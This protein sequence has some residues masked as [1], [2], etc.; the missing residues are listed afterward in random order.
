MNQAN[1]GRVR[2]G[3][4][5][6]GRCR[7]VARLAVEALRR[8]DHVL[9]PANDS[10]EQDSEPSEPENIGRAYNNIKV[11][12]N[13]KFPAF[14]RLDGESD[15]EAETPPNAEKEDI[16]IYSRVDVP[17]NLEAVGNHRFD[18]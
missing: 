1:R 18:Y 8:P 6:R 7:N 11:G 12:E 17:N 9:A 16:T 2:G 4:R 15:D 3:G 5:G 13:E 14:G 10:G